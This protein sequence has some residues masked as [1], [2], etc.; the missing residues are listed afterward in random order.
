[1]RNLNT[2]IIIF[3]FSFQ[4]NA[5]T[6]NDAT[7]NKYAVLT[8]TKS[9]GDF[10]LDVFLE[11]NQH[12]DLYKS[13][14]LDTIKLPNEYKDYTYILKGINYM[15]KSGYELVSSSMGTAQYRPT[16]REYVFR[17]KDIAK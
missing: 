9:M 5:Q 3:L 12:I 16:V 17:K 4:I 13:L 1:M 15:D 11:N 8:I 10:G 2:L 14:K 6:N 7:A